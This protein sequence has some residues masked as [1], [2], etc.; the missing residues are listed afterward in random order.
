MINVK[1]T[2]DDE[3]VFLHGSKSCNAYG[4]IEKI[5]VIVERLSNDKD[6]N[7]FEI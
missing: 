4:I 6:T 2:V 3:T 1:E 5:I 7:H